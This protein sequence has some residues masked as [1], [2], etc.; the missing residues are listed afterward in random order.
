MAANKRLTDLS[1]Y[2]SVLP[3]AS[4]LFGIYQPLIGWKSKRRL[5]RIHVGIKSELQAK[6][7]GLRDLFQGQ[8]EV[9]FNADQQME[10]GVVKI[11]EPRSS[12]LR[13]VNGSLL[14]A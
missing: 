12:V 1:D 5:R 2:V 9:P 14:I 10:A 11:G 6:L 3:Y 8:A 13:P 7:M 4:E